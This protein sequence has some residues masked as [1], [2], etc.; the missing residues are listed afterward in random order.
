MLMN[1]GD[2][3]MPSKNGLL[4]TL[5]CNADGGVA[6]ALEG[7]IFVAGAAIQ[8]LRDGLELIEDSAESESLAT[9]IKNQ[10][11]V[12]VVPA[13]A[14]LGAPYWNMDSRGAIFGL[15]RATGKAHLAKATLDAL[16]YRTKDVLDAMAK[17]SKI[18]LDILKAVSY[19]HLTLPTTPYV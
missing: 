1:I 7:S 8:W 9:S 15:T 13:F 16:A 2:E 19:T 11:E 14:G 6:Y 10:H 17:D 12:V 4:T 5:C 18:E 3:F